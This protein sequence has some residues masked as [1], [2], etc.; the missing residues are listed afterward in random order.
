MRDG[1]LLFGRGGSA[2]P[3]KVAMRSVRRAAGAEE[4]LALARL[5]AHADS[6]LG[7]P[8]DQQGECAVCTRAS[9]ESK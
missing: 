3:G 9:L 1:V 7:A 6:H 4:A 5:S 2:L 8:R